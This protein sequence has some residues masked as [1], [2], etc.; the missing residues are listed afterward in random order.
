[1][2]GF[3]FQETDPESEFYCGESLWDDNDVQMEYMCG[4]ASAN[5]PEYR[6]DNEYAVYTTTP[7]PNTLNI[8][9]LACDEENRW[10]FSN[11]IINTKQ[12]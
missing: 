11:N 6:H 5:P 3:V 1:M 4:T 7:T 8:I 9:H 12:Q 2:V 10:G